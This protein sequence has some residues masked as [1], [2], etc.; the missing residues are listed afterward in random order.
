MVFSL[1]MHLSPQRNSKI[2]VNRRSGE[3][4]MVLIEVKLQFW[5]I[6]MWL[7]DHC[8]IGVGFSSEMW[9]LFF[10]VL[11]TLR[12]CCCLKHREGL[13]KHFNIA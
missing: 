1:L 2:C 4:Q 5:L 12:T 8:L 6:I 7:R 10:L 11:C 9:N 13:H 3:M